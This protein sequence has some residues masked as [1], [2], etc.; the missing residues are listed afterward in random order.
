[1]LVEGHMARVARARGYDQYDFTPED[2]RDRPLFD[3]DQTPTFRKIKDTGLPLIVA[4]TASD[5]EWIYRPT[6]VKFRSWIGVPIVSQNGLI[7]F[8]SLNKIEPNYYTPRAAERLVTFA[9]QAAL[10]LENA[11]LYDN[12]QR[13]NQQLEE[14]VSARTEELR[15]AYEA[16]EK[17][18]RAKSD[19][20]GVASHE[21]RTPLTI[22]KG[23]S[24]LLVEDDTIKNS[25]YHKQLVDGILKGSVRMHEIVNSM[26]DMAKIDSRELQ[27]SPEPLTVAYLVKDV[28]ARFAPAL[29]ERR[30]AIVSEALTDLPPFEADPDG[31]TKVLWHVIGNAIKFTPD[32][33]KITINGQVIEPGQADFP[34]GGIEILVSDTGIGI[35]PAF[36]ELIFTKFY[37]TG[38]VALHSSG[39]TKFKGGGPGLGLAIARGIVSAHRGR[40]WVE[41]P[42]HDEKRCPGSRFH[43]ALP[44]RQKPAVDAE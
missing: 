42:G 21:L 14:M 1:M 8:F 27:L 6:T 35:D 24:Q 17:L 32:G 19:F 18:D 4:D 22:L 43:I 15:R 12:L 10:A 5:P 33:G 34:E 40:I 11:R 41:S 26:L 25:D 9:G 3:I 28:L 7:A 13:F 37:Q 31:L 44:L 38:K 29:K 23:Y 30:L 39:T 20:I 36:H 2:D 16:L